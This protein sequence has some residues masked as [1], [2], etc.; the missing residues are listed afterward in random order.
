[1]LPLQIVGA[2]IGGLS[3][4]LALARKGFKVN[5]HERTR[6]LREAGA[7]IQLGPNAFRALEELGV[8]HAIEQIA[9]EPHALVLLDSPSGAE[10]CRQELGS[11]FSERFGYSYR[12]GYRADV[13]QVLLHAVQEYRDRITLHLGSEIGTFSED[14][15]GVTLKTQH[16]ARIRGSALIGADGLWSTIRAAIIADGRPRTPGHI[17]YRAVLPVDRV[18]AELLTD[19]VQVWVGP[20]HHLVCYK[21]RAG[22][23][24]NIVAIFQSSRY[25]EGWDSA[26]DLQDL[27]TGFAEACSAVKHLLRHVQTWRMWVLCDRDPTPGWSVGRATL[28]GDAA[29][30]TLPYL[31]QGACMAIE[32]AV[33]LAHCIHQQPEDIPVALT[34]YEHA[35]LGRTGQ[36]QR[37]SRQMG[38][39]NHAT[40]EARETRNRALAARNPRDYE[41]N[42]WLFD[43]DAS[44]ANAQAKGLSFW[45]PPSGAH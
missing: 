32:D 3:T 29:H 28:L 20:R 23:L 38:E 9:F 2:G 8:Q 35:R 33:C 13:Q 11:P 17:A 42:A 25:V 39:M 5:V 34:E 41:S 19:N 26:A 16:G 40:G 18:P 27:Q 43:A 21:L 24:F 44:A 37:A 45:S 12:V 30:P 7:G 10:I 22:T 36:V 31:A 6:E 4:A 14:E 1:V 15:R